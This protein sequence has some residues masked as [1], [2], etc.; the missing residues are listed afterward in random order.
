MT[1]DTNWKTLK[2]PSLCVAGDHDS[3]LGMSMPNATLSSY[4][5]L[6]E[7]PQ[8][9]P[10]YFNTPNQEAVARKIAALEHA[11]EGII[12]SSGMAAIS[13]C[14]MSLVSKSQS[15]AV[16]YLACHR[17]ACAFAQWFSQHAVSFIQHSSSRRS[18]LRELTVHPQ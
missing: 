3:S 10:R 2:T 4:Y 18:L 14:V 9:Y 7:G 16:P 11:E 12:F 1:Q 17:A 6:D 15:G 5:Y 13:T 8:L